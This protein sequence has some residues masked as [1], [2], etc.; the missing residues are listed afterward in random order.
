MNNFFLKILENYCANITSKIHNI[1]GTVIENIL[2]P[3][4]FGKILYTP[5]TNVTVQ[6]IKK[7]KE[8]FKIEFTLY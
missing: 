8:L 2:K 3:I 6:L 4:L 1:G 5:K 7:V